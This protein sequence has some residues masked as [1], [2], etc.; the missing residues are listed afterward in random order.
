[1][2]LDFRNKVVV[3]TGAARG[4]GAS[5]AKAFGDAGAKVVLL[6]VSDG[7][8]T[9]ASIGGEYIKHDV[10][11]AAAWSQL[12]EHIHGRYGRLDALVNNAAI[13]HPARLE[14]LTLEAWN[15][16]IAVN[17]TGAF[18]GCQTAVRL[19]R[20]NPAAAPATIVNVASI[21]A[22]LAMAYD[23]AYT[24]SKGGLVALTKS[25]AHYCARERLPI[26]CNVVSPGAIRTPL[27]EQFIAASPDPKATEAALNKLQPVGHMA[28]PEDVANLI[29]YLS[30]PQSGFITGSEMI[31][32]GGATSAANV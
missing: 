20:A 11:S 27:A 22:T 18:L 10:S 31:I 8:E 30:S 32:D 7:A 1:M 28:A 29:V 2:H 16:A 21:S 15:M 25:V 3:V 4:V 6:D 9:A 13:E 24:A 26:R 17:L 12:G 5:T 23:S 19:M 14:D